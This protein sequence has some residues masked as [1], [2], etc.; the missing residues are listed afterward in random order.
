MENKVG[1]YIRLRFKRNFEMEGYPEK[2][3]PLA[4]S[5]VRQRRRLGFAGEHMILQRTRELKRSVV[6]RGHPYNLNEMKAKSK[7]LVL[8]LGSRDPRFGLLHAGGTTPTGGQVPARPMT[9]LGED[10]IAGLDNLLNYI[11]QQV[12]R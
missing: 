5:T 2:W 11:I 10:D 7:S 8:K 6:E 4:P 1:D 3:A 12:V 9:V